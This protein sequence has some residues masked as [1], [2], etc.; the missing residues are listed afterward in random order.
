[1]TLTVWA[2]RVEG[3]SAS[4]IQTFVN[5]ALV[6]AIAAYPI[7]GIP[8]PPSI[9]GYLYADYLAGVVLGAHSSIY[10]VDGTGTD[11]ALNPDEVVTLATTVNVRIVEVS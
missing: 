3:V 9:Q 8:K 6:A 11:V 1:M 7:G 2:K 4:D 10:D 5:D